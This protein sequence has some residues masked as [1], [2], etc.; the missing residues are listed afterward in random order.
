MLGM[1]VGR[2]RRRNAKQ[3]EAKQKVAEK[4]RERKKSRY[5]DG[6]TA[7]ELATEFDDRTSED[8]GEEPMHRKRRRNGKVAKRKKRQTGSQRHPSPRSGDRVNGGPQKERGEDTLSGMA[9]RRS[10]PEPKAGLQDLDEGVRRRHPH[11]STAPTTTDST[12]KAS[13]LQPCDASHSHPPQ[14]P[15][16]RTGSARAASSSQRT[17]PSPSAAAAPTAQT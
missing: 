9:G 7:R 13:L 16:G 2:G 15:S 10:G 4:K 3:S 17:S 8:P 14:P 11:L 5:L 1:R 12:I 6:M